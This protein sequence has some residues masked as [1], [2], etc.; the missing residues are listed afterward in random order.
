MT[1][2]ENAVWKKI[3]ATLGSIAIPLYETVMGSRKCTVLS[4]GTILYEAD[5]ISH[6]KGIYS[7]EKDNEYRGKDKDWMQHC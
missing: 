7:L 1:P 5:P 3:E 4:D 6:D 2:E